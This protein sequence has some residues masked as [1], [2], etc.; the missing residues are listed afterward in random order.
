MKC[1]WWWEWGIYKDREEEGESGRRK[2]RG[3]GRVVCMAEVVGGGVTKCDG[4]DIVKGKMVNTWVVVV[5]YET[6]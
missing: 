5:G 2:V 3:K 4:W 6:E 1:K